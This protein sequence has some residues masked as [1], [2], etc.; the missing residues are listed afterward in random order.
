MQVLSKSVS[1]A[2]KLLK[3]E[4]YSEMSKF[5]EMFNRFF[6]CLNTRRAGKGKEK[7]NGD[8]FAL[9]TGFVV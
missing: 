1:C 4:E 6:D 8:L 7:R 5:C 3:N 9:V 2:F